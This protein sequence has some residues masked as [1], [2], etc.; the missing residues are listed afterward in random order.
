MIKTLLLS[1]CLYLPNMSQAQVNPK[2]IKLFPAH[3]VYKIDN[4]ISKINLTEDKQ[5]K[6]GQKLYTSDS[7]ATISLANG[8]VVDKS[9]SYYT[10][11][12]HFLKSILSAKELDNYGYDKMVDVIK[13]K[14]T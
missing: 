11:D 8:E 4:V 2:V 12:T 5:I 3:I 14:N 9:K 10:I 13:T 6:I 7:L 1:I